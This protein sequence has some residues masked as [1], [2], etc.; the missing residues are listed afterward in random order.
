MTER[1]RELEQFF[2]EQ[3]P[4]ARA[5]AVRVARAEG[6]TVVLSAPLAAN[7]NHHGTLFGGSAS[8]LAILAAWGWIHLRLDE[9]GLDPDLVIQHSR[10]EFLT[11]GVGEIRARC[12]G[13]DERGWR[14]FLRTYRRFDRA[15]LELEAELMADCE[16][17]ARLQG[18]FVALKPNHGSR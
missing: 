13:T 7:E 11:P 18:A 14:R 5:M 12:R 9:E 10:M 17:V 16:T 2:H 8:A 15:R 6:D 4:L 1:A 3:I